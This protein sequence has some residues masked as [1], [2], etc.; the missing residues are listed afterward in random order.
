[1]KWARFTVILV[2]MHFQ[3]FMSE[4]KDHWCVGVD[5]TGDITNWDNFIKLKSEVDEDLGDV[6]LVNGETFKPG[7]IFRPPP[8]GYS[9]REHG[10]FKVS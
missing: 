4:T 10:L 7:S 6:H 9:G 5:D 8:L 3:Q 2:T 1:M